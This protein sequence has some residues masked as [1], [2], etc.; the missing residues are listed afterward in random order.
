MPPIFAKMSSS[1]FSHSHIQ[2]IYILHVLVRNASIPRIS[3]A[4]LKCLVRL[5]KLADLGRAS[6]EK[7]LVSLT[8]NF[9][10]SGSQAR[11]LYLS[12]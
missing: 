2:N 11:G 8:Q 9:P 6:E 3:G 5:Y 7:H 12:Q 1:E 10:G 4:P